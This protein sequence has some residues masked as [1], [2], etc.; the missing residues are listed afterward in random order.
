[1]A[2]WGQVGSAFSKASNIYGVPYAVQNNTQTFAAGSYDEPTYSVSGSVLTGSCFFMSVS[3]RF[4]GEERQFLETGLLKSQD[5]KAYIP[6]G[7]SI[8]E[9]ADVVI[10]GGSWK[11]SAV[12]DGAISYYPNATT[13]VYIKIYLSIK[14][15]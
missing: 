4:G 14:K 15:P 10:A 13:P 11:I 6:S 8:D 9:F 5:M 1:M 7:L 3:T 2:Y 12:S